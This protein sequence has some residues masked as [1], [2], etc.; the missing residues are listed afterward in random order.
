MGHLYHGFVSHNQTVFDLR[1]AFFWVKSLFARTRQLG[2]PSGKT[3]S[4]KLKP[5]LGSRIADPTAWWLT[6]PSEKH[7]S[8]LG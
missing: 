5:W 7:E 4:P 2:L 1:S 3:N 6:Y 8:Q